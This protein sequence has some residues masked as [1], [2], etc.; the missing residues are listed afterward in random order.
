MG[1]KV[2]EM[3]Q[4]DFN[5]YAADVVLAS[6]FGDND[7]ENPWTGSSFFGAGGGDL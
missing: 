7:A 5:L 3:P 1:K 6:G 2:Y 4:A